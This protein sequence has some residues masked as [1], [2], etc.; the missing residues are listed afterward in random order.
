MSS[1]T[2]PNFLRACRAP[3]VALALIFSACSHTPPTLTVTPTSTTLLTGASEK[4]SATVTGQTDTPV[5]WT[6]DSGT[7][8]GDGS[9]T[10]PA[11]P[12]TYRVTAMTHGK[13]CRRGMAVVDTATVTVTNAPAVSIVIHPAQVSLLPSETSTFIARVDGA[14]ETAVTWSVDGGT[15]TTTNPTTYTAPSSEGT[16]HVIATSKADPNKRA[17]ASVLVRKRP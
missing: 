1:D 5:T 13:G 4:F 17:T 15:I 7:V 10:A 16:Y 11:A 2:K 14:S 3:L 6:T 8:A 12:G 9:Y